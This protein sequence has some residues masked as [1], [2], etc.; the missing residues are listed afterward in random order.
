MEE[1]GQDALEMVDRLKQMGR[2]V[3]Y[4]VFPDEGHGFTKS[5]NARKGF[6][7]AADFLV[8]KLTQD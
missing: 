4:M 5:E 8:A 7:A 2:K 6:G 1:T 3:E